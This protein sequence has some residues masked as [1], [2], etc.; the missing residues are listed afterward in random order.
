[1]TDQDRQLLDNFISYEQLRG[2]K[3]YRD[4]RFILKAF[5]DYLD[6]SALT[7]TDI[8]HREAQ[9][10]Q[11]YAASLT[12]GEGKSRYTSRSIAHILDVA[13]N[14]YSYLKKKHHVPA[15]PFTAIQR[16]KTERYLPRKLPDI[17]TMERLLSL[18][19]TFWKAGNLKQRRSRYKLHVIAEMM[20]ATGMRIS[21]VANLRTEDINFQKQT[22]TIRESKTGAQRTA[23]LNE[24]ACKV[25]EKYVNSMRSIITIHPNSEYIFG[26]KNSNNLVKIVNKQLKTVFK[27]EG[28]DSF[29][30]H[31][32]R[33]CLGY[34]L[35]HKGCDLRFIQLILGH[36]QLK[37]TVL[38]T[39]VN[40]EDLKNQLDLF[41]PRKFQDK[42]HEPE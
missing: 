2:F 17:R 42:A 26:T 7:F 11:T 15:N 10:F 30:S 5:F 19:R 40:K 33:H 14:L 8:R 24:Y 18:L 32:F 9:E 23:Y 41:H 12:T 22:I 27:Q 1:M 25:L 4:I 39:K 6:E 36:E 38:Y 16:I 3:K 34:H 29:T 20:Y 31:S 21:E 37:S 35:L 28:F 13:S